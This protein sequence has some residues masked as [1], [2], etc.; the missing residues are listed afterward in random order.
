MKLVTRFE[1]ASRSTEQ[2]Q[3]LYREAFNA[4]SVAPRGSQEYRSALQ[5]MRII[6]DEL[7]TRMPG[8]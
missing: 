2:L 5:S 7:A 4:F 6:E 1:A 3:G 8:F